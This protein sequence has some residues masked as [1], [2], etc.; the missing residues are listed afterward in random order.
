ML[1]PDAETLS[2]GLPDICCK[3]DKGKKLQGIHQVGNPSLGWATIATQ[4]NIHLGF[5]TFLPTIDQ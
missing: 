4:D 3:N 5:D 1:L 2:L